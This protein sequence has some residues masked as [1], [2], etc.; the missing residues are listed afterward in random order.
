M[1]EPQFINTEFSMTFL[2]LPSGVCCWH[3]AKIGHW[4]KHIRQ[5][6]SKEELEAPT[7]RVN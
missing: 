4:C 3:D 1:N 6:V 5:W 2:E 7:F